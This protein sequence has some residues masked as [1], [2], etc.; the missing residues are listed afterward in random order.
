MERHL[1]IFVN[2]QQDDWSDKLPITEF[3][4]NNNDFASSRLSPFFALKSLHPQMSF[5]VVNFLDIIT[6]ERINMK[7]AIDI[8]D[9]M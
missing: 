3:A 9:F 7:K 5:D 6:R 4:A 1:Y 2:N 8:S